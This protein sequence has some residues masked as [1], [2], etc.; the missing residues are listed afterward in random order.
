MSPPTPTPGRPGR[1]VAC[2]ALDE[3]GAGLARDDERGLVLHIAGA[4]PGEQVRVQVDHV[5][6]HRK[7]GLR[8]AW[9]HVSELLLPSPQRVP[10]ACPAQGQCGGC[11]LQH[12]AYPAQL[13]WKRGLV[14][15]ELARRE[16]LVTVPVAPCVPSPRPLEYRNQGKYACGRGP[17][18]RLALGAYAPRSHALLDL[19]GCRVLE[20]PLDQVATELQ[21]ELADAGIE[22][23][24]EARACGLLRHVVLRRNAAGQILVALVTSLGPG[25]AIDPRLLAAAR[26]LVSDAPSRDGPARI[27]GV[28]ES[29]NP[30]RG[31]TIFG[32]DERRLAGV[33][34][35]D[36]ELLGLRL[37]L[38]APAFFQINRH[39]A[40]LAYGRIRAT[41]A[42]L[43]GSL[44]TIVDAY[45]G[46]GGIGLLLA[47]HARRVVLVEDNAAA[48]TA[49]REAVTRNDLSGV[50]VLTA[51]AADA[52]GSLDT[53]DV[54]VLNPPR[55][56][57]AGRALRATARLRPRLVAYLSCNPATLARDLDL[58]AGLGLT[59]TEV[60]PLDMHPHT[61]HVEALA[62]L[63]PA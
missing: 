47:P 56:G 63:R 9:A 5:S 51:D 19:S 3:G 62:F 12:L 61:P 6:H 55:G 16:S 30:A 59:C 40:A 37:R 4:L 60:T 10:P 22:P 27:V 34:H 48:T 21:R 26:R 44:D 25:S 7:S 35:L 2:E 53:A 23:Y 41:V 33:D 46:V 20:P 32:T 14:V 1:I 24:D 8:D 38:R 43:A 54:V 11:P 39:V 18:G 42:A 28:V 52:L 45:A 13:E 29:L 31:N 15:A 50:E 49:A 58:L 36:E 17:D 57:C